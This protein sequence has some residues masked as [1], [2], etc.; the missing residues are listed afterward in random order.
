VGS[1][2]ERKQAMF[3]LADAFVALPGG[4]GTLDELTE[5]AT[6]GQLDRD[7]R[8]PPARRPRQ[9]RRHRA[10][11]GGLRSGRQASLGSSGSA[12]RSASAPRYT[13][14]P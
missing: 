13:P 10:Q 3:E 9:S 6:W 12:S 4:L 7:A 2:H 8:M 11:L 1:L 5:M 14:A